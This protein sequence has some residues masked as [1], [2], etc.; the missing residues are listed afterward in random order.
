[1][2]VTSKMACGPQV[3]SARGTGQVRGLKTQVARWPQAYRLEAPTLETRRGGFNLM[4]GQCG[5]VHS[6]TQLAGI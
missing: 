1:M 2:V 6:I 5:P 3:E 4:G